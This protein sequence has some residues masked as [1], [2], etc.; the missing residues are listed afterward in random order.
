VGRARGLME[1]SD[2]GYRGNRCREIDIARPGGFLLPGFY[3]PCFR[4]GNTLHNL[5]QRGPE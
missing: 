3:H 5:K 2:P 1:P 4:A